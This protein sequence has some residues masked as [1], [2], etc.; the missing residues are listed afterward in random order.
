M[1]GAVTAQLHLTNQS[2][3]AADEVV[4]LYVS[5]RGS[6]VERPLKKLVGF[7]RIR[8]QPGETKSVHLTVQAEELAIWDVTRDRFCLETAEYIFTAGG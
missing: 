4:Q 7:T 3:I 2:I 8:L 5:V 6:R 1:D